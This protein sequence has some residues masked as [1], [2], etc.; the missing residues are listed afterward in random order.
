MVRLSGCP[1][2]VARRWAEQMKKLE[3]PYEYV[4]VPGGDHISVAFENLPKL[5]AFFDKQTW[6]RKGSR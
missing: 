6:G 4:D 1:V 2:A 3:M 5:F